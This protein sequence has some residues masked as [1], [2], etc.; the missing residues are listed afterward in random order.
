VTLFASFQLYAR[1]RW[2]Q[3]G[4][5]IGIHRDPSMSDMW[6]GA[7]TNIQKGGNSQLFNQGKKGTNELT[8]TKMQT[9]AFVKTCKYSSLSF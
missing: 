8:T 3:E 4:V 9:V 6:G 2:Q 7:G 5:G 1:G